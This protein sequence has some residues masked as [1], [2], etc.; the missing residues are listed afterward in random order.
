MTE[1]LEIIIV[2]C[3]GIFIFFIAL[4]IDLIFGEYRK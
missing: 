2:F 3:V 4:I 1:E